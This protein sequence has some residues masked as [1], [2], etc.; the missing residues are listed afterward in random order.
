[1]P[2][3]LS[4]SLELSALLESITL[5]VI[6][7]YR[8]GIQTEIRQDKSLEAQDLGR[9]KTQSLSASPLR[10]QSMLPPRQQRA[11]ASPGRAHKS[12]CAKF[13]CGSIV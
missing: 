9:F 1:M 4:G 8:K 10:S 12:S 11:D 13:Y 3:G 6:G 7:H 5:V 2:S